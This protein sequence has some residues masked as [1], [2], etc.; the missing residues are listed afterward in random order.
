MIFF[1]FSVSKFY[2]VFCILCCFT[3]LLIFDDLFLRPLSLRTTSVNE[4]PAVFALKKLSVSS[5]LN[6]LSLPL[7]PIEKQ[8]FFDCAYLELTVFVAPLVAAA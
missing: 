2:N 3:F 1:K 8:S 6:S 4:L 7:G 5:M